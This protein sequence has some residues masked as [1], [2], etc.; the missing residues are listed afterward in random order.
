[1]APARLSARGH[2]RELLTDCSHG[3]G[4]RFGEDR[5]ESLGGRS[6]LWSPWLEQLLL[7]SML[8]HPGGTWTWGRFV[9]VHPVDNLDMADMCARYQVLLR[10]PAKFRSTTLEDVLDSGVLPARSVRSLRERYVAP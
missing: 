9:V 6:D 1:M 5:V 8:Q 2:R 3:F 10:D 4:L 7:F